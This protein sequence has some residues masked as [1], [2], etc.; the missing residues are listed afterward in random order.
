M[1]Q[2]L[3][4]GCGSRYIPSWTNVDFISSGEGVIAH[5]LVEGIPFNEST[6]EAVYHSHVLEHFSKPDGER[7][8]KE[9]YRVLA[10]GGTLR[11]VVPD[12]ERIA[13]SYVHCLKEA[14]EQPNAL[15]TANHAWSTIEMVD[16]IAR[17]QSGGQMLSY[18]TQ[19]EIINQA[20]VEER[21]GY[22]FTS[23]RQRYLNPAPTIAA[24]RAS[25]SLASRIKG[26]I[27]SKLKDL[28]LSAE[29]K[30]YLEVGEVR[31]TGEV[32]QWMYDR[33]SLHKLL[34]ASGFKDIRVVSAHT[35]RIPAWE[36]YLALDTEKGQIRKPD[37]LFMEAQK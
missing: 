20:F 4:L 19:P 12:L 6:F 25:R 32:H 3:N 7:F 16:Q 15:H 17:H 29:E 21:I 10:P 11:V 34:E 23:F 9:C 35:S 30:K 22:E 18:W 33:F 26:K 27:K 13:I 28:V 5:N 14:L 2:Y 36:Q 8:I 24:P 37:S 31:L 1:K